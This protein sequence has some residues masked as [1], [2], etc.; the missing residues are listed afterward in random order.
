MKLDLE[1][2]IRYA[3]GRRAGILRR[4]ILND[5]GQVESVVMATSRFI[6]RNAIVPLSRYRALMFSLLH[7][8]NRSCR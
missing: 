3:D 7:F 8:T 2:E 6:S 1:T 5:N 4:V